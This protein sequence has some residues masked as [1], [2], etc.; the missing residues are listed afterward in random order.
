MKTYHIHIKGQVQGVG[1]RPFVYRIAQKFGVGG[2]V[3][4]GVDGVHIFFNA[5]ES[6]SR[7]FHQALVNGAPAI[8]CI[9]SSTLLETP[10]QNFAEFRVV[11]SVPQGQHDVL[12]TPDFALC[13]DCRKE[14]TSMIGTNRRAGYAFTTCTVC[15]P[16]YSI[17]N[18]LPFDRENTS[19]RDYKMCASCENEYREPGDRRYFS[20]TNS[21]HTCGIGLLLTSTENELP[22]T[23][24]SQIVSK[25][26]QLL[27]QGKIIAV[28]GIGGY[29]LM[30]DA[31]NKE[32]ICKLRFYKQRSSKPFALM[33]PD[34]EMLRSD[35]LLSPMEEECLLSPPS[36][37]VLLQLKENIS[38]RICVP[39]IA[40][41]LTQVGAMLPY[42]PVY[43]LLLSAFN[44]P[45]IATSANINSSPIIHRDSDI[46]RLNKMANAIMSNNREIVVP[47]DDSVIKFSAFTSQ[48]IIIRR[49][50]GL[51]PTYIN[52]ELSLPSKN[53][54]ATGA[55]LKSTFTLTHRQNIY[56]SQYL[57]DLDDYD[58][59]KNYKQ[60]LNHFYRLLDTRPEIILTDRHPDYFSTNYGLDLAK[61]LH[62]PVRN[63]QHHEAHFAAVLGENNLLHTDK[64]VLGVIWD[65]VGLGNDGHV[66]GGEFFIYKNYT[67]ERCGHFGYFD[68]LL[69]D[70]MAREPRLSA[71][72]AT[73][74]IADIETLLRKKFSDTEWTNYQK[75]LTNKGNLQT[76]SV[77]RIFDAVA[78]LLDLSD[79]SSYE[80][81]AAMSLETLAVQYFRRNGLIISETYFEESNILETPTRKMFQRLIA[82]IKNGKDKSFIAAKFH[83]SLAT[84]VSTIATKLSIENIALSGG[85]FQNALLIDLIKKQITPDQNVFLHRQLSP[86]DE[87]ISFG[88]LCCYRIEEQRVKKFPLTNKEYVLSHTR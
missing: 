32:S 88:Q 29:L 31:A 70:K 82:D 22:E 21:C 20:Q 1:F 83:Y 78:S 80:G 27:D 66:W 19:M 11:D 77:G 30:C 5:N 8:S 52:P 62:V 67:M 24:Y 76:S 87:C 68:Y 14:L 33:Y 84:L 2:E 3:Y 18:R 86:N 48:K 53:V 10:N 63:Y 25:A 85:V 65:G 44:K 73:R 60:C 75:I 57:G 81:E 39:E 9:T 43:V 6:K 69:G 16:R 36:P 28:K 59:Q 41:G 15:G 71:L 64:P 4:N 47:Q 7:E 58:V 56:I 35:V 13:T 72:A 26:V 37:I 42:A 74:G 12:L 40:P 55:L 50:R 79:S 54:L 34:V 23:D 61:E 17:I 49:S 46:E 51:S 45:V 38:S